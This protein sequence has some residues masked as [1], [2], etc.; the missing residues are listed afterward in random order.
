MTVKELITYLSDV[1]MEAEIFVGSNELQGLGVGTEPWQQ[2]R[3]DQ[4]LITRDPK[5]SLRYNQADFDLDS[6]MEDL[7]DVTAILIQ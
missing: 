3:A 4:V 5:D 7:S 1:N 6:G 2:S